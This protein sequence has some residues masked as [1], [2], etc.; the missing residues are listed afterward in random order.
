[1]TV[2]KEMHTYIDIHTHKISNASSLEIINVFAGE[3]APVN[4]DGFFSSAIHPWHVD[5]DYEEKLKQL[6]N[7]VA[8]TKCIAIGETGLDKVCK[9]DFKMQI[10]V[11]K[12]HIKLSEK[13]EK[14][15]ILHCVKA[16]NEILNIRTELKARQTW[17]FHGFNGSYELA[18]RCIENSCMLSYGQ[19]LLNDDTK[20]AKVFPH[21]AIENVFFETDDEVIDI[22]E[23]YARAAKIKGIEVDKLIVAIKN[24]FLKIFDV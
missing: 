13:Y 8:D 6:K 10:E 16:Y 21:I 22:S 2:A 19:L 12:E 14:P 7:C 20:A 11:F 18:E 17:I 23:V 24:N 1:M 9:A 3:K 5:D 15:L 4:H